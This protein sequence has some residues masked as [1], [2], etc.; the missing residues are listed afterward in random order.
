MN[1]NVF[2]QTLKR[3]IVSAFIDATEMCL[4]RW[5]EIYTANNIAARL[6]GVTFERFLQQPEEYL[7]AAIFDKPAPLPE[8]REYFPLLPAQ[9]DA[10]FAV[11]H[12]ENLQ[13]YLEI[14]EAGLTSF[15]M[16]HRG[17]CFVEPLKHHAYVV[18][19]ARTVGRP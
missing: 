13:D 6:P 4:H 18:S 19:R 9:V 10:A 5:G 7:Q 14:L 15:A 8:D 11:I 2:A 12:Q 1:G 3:T 16:R 17:N